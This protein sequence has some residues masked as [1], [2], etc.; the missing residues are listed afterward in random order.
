[1]FQR[2]I[3]S[4]TACRDDMVSYLNQRT[5]Q[6]GV[7]EFDADREN[8]NLK[9]FKTSYAASVYSAVTKQSQGSEHSIQCRKSIKVQ[10]AEAA[11]ELAA[12]QVRLQS[13]EMKEK[14]RAYLAELEAHRVRQNLELDQE[15]GHRRRLE[16]LEAQHDVQEIN[17]RCSILQAAAN[18]GDGEKSVAGAEPKNIP[19]NASMLNPSANTFVSQKPLNAGTSHPVVTNSSIDETSFAQVL[20]SV[21]KQNRLP[22][23]VPKMF[24]GN[25]IEFVA[26]KRSFKTLIEGKG[27]T[28][29]EKNYYLQQYVAGDARDAIAGRFFGSSELDYQK[30]WETLERRFGHS[31]KIQEAFRER[32]ERWPKIGHKDGEALQK[33]AY[34]LRSCLDAKPYVKG[35]SV[36]DDCKENQKMTSKLPDWVITRWSRRVS[37]SLEQSTEYATFEQFVIFVEKEARAACHPVASIAGV[38][39]AGLTYSKHQTEKDKSFR[40]L[41]TDQKSRSTKIRDRT[42][43]LCPFCKGEHHLADCVKFAEKGLEERNTYIQAEKRCFGCLRTGHYTKQYKVRHTCRTCQGRHPTV[44][45]DNSRRSGCRPVQQNPFQTNQPRAASLNA[46]CGDTSTTNVVPVW[47]SSVDSIVFKSNLEHPRHFIT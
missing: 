12:R 40:S 27:I 20:A 29:E 44:L 47:V 15:I 8:T 24:S 21:M 28:P 38:K 11:A 7:M 2:R 23:P 39:G 1:M 43:K 16:V 19:N 5:I 36:L 30:A 14:E 31:F 18:D 10:A 25:P 9:G 22:V 45:H 37:E 26:F 4:A 35:L 17:A 32:L 3:D 33:Y 46:D 6:I 34:I 13:L 42:N 41:V